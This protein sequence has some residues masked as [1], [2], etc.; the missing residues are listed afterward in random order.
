M[1]RF[2]PDRSCLLLVVACAGALGLHARSLLQPQLYYD[3]FGIAIQ[4]LT[5]ARTCDNLQVP[6]NEHW[7]PLTR[8]GAWLVVECA[9]GASAL[10]L[11]AAV[12]TRLVLIA[13]IL[14]VFLFVKRERGHAF[15]GLVGATLFGI[16]AVY[17]EAVYWS[18]AT[19][20]IA[21]A[22]TTLFALLGAQRWRQ[23]GRRTALAGSAFGAA[24]A[25]G[26]FAGGILAGPLAAL[27]LVAS[28]RRSWRGP[29]AVPM[30]G[31]LA[32]LA[33][34]YSIAGSAV[35][36]QVES[37][38]SLTDSLQIG[39]VNTGRSIVDNLA[40]GA[41]GVSG[42][43]FPIPIVV[44]GL[45]LL[46]IVAAW[47]WRRAPSRE[48][49]VLGLGFIL[50]SDLLIFTARAG[51]PWEETLS[52]W[53]RYN[54]WPWLGVTL[55]VC[56]GISRPHGCT[57]DALGNREALVLILLMAA[58]FAVQFPRAIRETPACDPTQKEA[59][60]RVDRV[61]AR[62]RLHRIS[63]DDARRALPPAPLLYFPEGS[64]WML[65]R[66]GRDPAPLGDSEIR[67]LLL[68]D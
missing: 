29:A 51:F 21:A 66:G 36:A 17:L 27:Y 7:W 41:V 67:R 57:G 10:P 32:Y 9:G 6:V 52:G 5:W 45:L 16:S 42:V 60:D 65:L 39:I 50:L 33:L 40:L 49:I 44:V 54:V 8:L 3:D 58:L 1:T 55:I 64:A 46:A 34:A 20:A 22:A 2:R 24:L 59:L 28:N 18:A 12:A 62:C 23:T 53:S 37:R 35:R 63:A 4:S 19:P 61:D 13:T 56:G 38:P 43:S 26:W 68:E 48:L 15:F 14:L 25:P 47:W 30:L 11:A 31:S